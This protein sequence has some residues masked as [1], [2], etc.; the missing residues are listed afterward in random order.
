MPIP[1]IPVAI[2]GALGLVGGIA[3]NSNDKPRE[4]SNTNNNPQRKRGEQETQAT[5]G[6]QGQSLTAD[7]LENDIGGGQMQD[8]FKPTGIA[9][10]DE[11]LK[12]GTFTSM[13]GYALKQMGVNFENFGYQGAQ[14]INM[15]A[16][17]KR[18]Q[19]FNKIIDASATNMSIDN[20][21][22]LSENNLGVWGGADRLANKASY[23][24]L[25]MSDDNIK[26]MAE[27]NNF[28]NRKAKS[29]KGGKPAVQDRKDLEKIYAPKLRSEVEWLRLLSTAKREQLENQY[30]QMEVLKT[31][32]LTIPK[33]VQIDYEY[34]VAGYQEL[35]RQIQAI[36]S[37]KQKKF[38]Y[39]IWKQYQNRR[40]YTP[41]T[42]EDAIDIEKQRLYVG[43]GGYARAE[44]PT[45]RN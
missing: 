36:E 32:G 22:G 4:P 25:D 6:V 26:F 23:G 21:I 18:K 1:I 34:N 42:Q 3:L 16:K 41:K 13:D 5:Q 11:K 7:G 19:D 33:A 30:N 12:N 28:V 24:Y 44:M 38:D 20:L 37:G 29:D 14:N 10:A 17:I 8:A 45:E 2:A 31:Y 40:P 9:W 15:D 27:L 39:K 43:N 35:D